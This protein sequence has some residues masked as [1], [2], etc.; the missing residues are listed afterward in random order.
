MVVKWPYACGPVALHGRSLG[1]APLAAGAYRLQAGIGL[2]Y[3][4]ARVSVVQLRLQTATPDSCP[5]TA[6]TT[7][8][9][10]VIAWTT[11]INE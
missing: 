11:V 1:Q 9:S 3:Y 7:A 6:F 2:T 5:L 10:G 8:T 4:G